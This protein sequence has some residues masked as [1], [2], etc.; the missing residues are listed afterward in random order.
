[1]PST[2]LTLVPAALLALAA[3]SSEPSAPPMLGQ[4]PLASAPS[5]NTG[6]GVE[7]IVNGS[8]VVNFVP[9]GSSLAPFQFVAW[10]QVDGTAGGHFR[11]FRFGALGT[12]D[13]EGVVT[14]VTTDPN[15]PERA[16]IAGTITVNRGIPSF[17]IH[18]KDAIF[19]GSFSPLRA[20]A[21]PGSVCNR[22]TFSPSRTPAC[23]YEKCAVSRPPSHA[24][25]QLHC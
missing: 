14:C 11:Q 17:A 1:M 8:G 6:N 20:T 7:V 21:A 9:G 22:L 10:R 24:C 16:R 18:R 3:C 23:R 12:V 15:F 13:F 4:L 5:L 25:A 19:G 2:R